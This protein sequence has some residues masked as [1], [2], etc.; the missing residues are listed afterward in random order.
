[1]MTALKWVGTVVLLLFV[2]ATIGVL[3]S[4]EVLTSA[5]I[6]HET[7]STA[8]LEGNSLPGDEATSLEDRTSTVSMDSSDSDTDGENADA[9]RTSGVL[10]AACAVEAIYFHNSLRCRTCKNIEELA[11]AVLEAEFP[12]E[13]AAG[14]LK[15]STINM[16]DQTQVVAE[17][18]LV[19]PTLVLLRRMGGQRVDWIALDET[20]ILIRSAT[21]FSDYIQHTTLGFLE[22]CHE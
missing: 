21:R 14:C 3:I 13:F 1:M 5:P 22:A 15:W 12:D 11:K 6:V 2:G 9:V 10:S 18:E 7:G 19:R 17:Y 20:W 16:E 4:R 8:Q